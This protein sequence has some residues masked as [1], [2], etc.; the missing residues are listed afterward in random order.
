MDYKGFC[1]LICADLDELFPPKKYLQNPFE[2]LHDQKT[3][4][5]PA[6]DEFFKYT[7]EESDLKPL[8]KATVLKWRSL[9]RAKSEIE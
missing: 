6:I 5:E 3:A 9:G 2:T 8:L 4:K 1:E 7:I